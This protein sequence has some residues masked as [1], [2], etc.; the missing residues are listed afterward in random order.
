[1]IQGDALLKWYG[2]PRLS[3]QGEF[4]ANGWDNPIRRHERGVISM[5]RAMDPDS[6]GSRFLSCMRTRPIWM[7]QYA[8]FGRVVGEWMCGQNRGLQ[9]GRFDRPVDDQVMKRVYIEEMAGKSASAARPLA[10]SS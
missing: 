5:A 2:R 8:A 10:D 1:M 6:A 7:E 4:A 9:G 3:D